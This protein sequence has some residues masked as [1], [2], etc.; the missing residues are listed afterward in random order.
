LPDAGWGVCKGDKVGAGKVMKRIQIIIFFLALG[1]ILSSQQTLPAGLLSEIKLFDIYAFDELN[2]ITVGD[3]GIVMITTDG[4][5]SWSGTKN[6]GG[7][8]RTLQA[9]DFV[10]PQTGW[11]VGYK[12]SILKTIDGGNSWQNLSVDSTHFLSSVDFTDENNG[13]AGGATVDICTLFKTNDGGLN[14]DIY[15]LIEGYSAHNFFDIHFVTDSIGW[16]VADQGTIIKTI[17]GGITWSE[18]NSST[19]DWLMSVSFVNADTGWV[20]GWF[21]TILKTI[22]GGETWDPQ[23]TETNDSF[24]AVHFTNADT[25][26]AVGTG[27][28][29]TIN[30]G[31]NWNLQFETSE[32]LQDVDFVNSQVGWAVGSNGSIYK[33]ENGGLDW[34]KQ[35]I[36][37]VQSCDDQIAMNQSFHLEQNY[38]N[39]F[40]PTTTIKYNVPQNGFVKITISDVLG[41]HIKTLINSNQSAGHYSTVWDATNSNNRS[42]AAGLYFCR[43]DVEEFVKV[44]KLALIK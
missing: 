23:S 31:S 1:F 34:T 10:N 9:I 28:Y 12:G 32:K 17:D 29:N 41:R 27:I 11:I 24:F 19:V 30:G 3:N 36:T 43:M 8:N 33:T 26:W 37:S 13:L 35:I 22:D 21:G 44:I 4:G 2:A 38:P 16:A 14:W 15:H 25:G 20:A 42:V 18:Q 39:P 7:T 5:K 40:N 6:T